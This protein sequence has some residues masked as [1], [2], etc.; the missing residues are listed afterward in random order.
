M[1]I[2]VQVLVALILAH[3]R[4]IAITII[5]GGVWT[6]LGA[7]WQSI[8]SATRDG[9][10]RRWPRWIGVIRFLVELISNVIKAFQIAR[11]QVVQAKVR[12]AIAETPV[13]V[14]TPSG[15]SAR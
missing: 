4:A 10:E 6:M 5:V 15:E 14:E 2:L 11:Y 3:P 13:A 12:P 7:A 1:D 9:W 8:P